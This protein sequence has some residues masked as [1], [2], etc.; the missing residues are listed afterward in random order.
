MSLLQLLA[1]DNYIPVNK[2]FIKSFGLAEAVL[3][4]E[5]C[6]EYTY[7]ENEDKLVDDMFYCS[8]AKLEDRTGLS[9]YQQR[10]A[11]QSLKNAGILETSL[12]GCPATKY[13]KINSDKL[14]NFL[15]TSSKKT[16]QLDVKKLQPSNN[17]NIK[18]ENKKDIISKDIISVQKPEFEFGKPKEKKLS[19]YHKCVAHVN[20]FT[21][22]DPD[23]RVR[24]LLLDFLN[25]LVDMGK[26]R[27][28]KQFVGILNKLKE[29]GDTEDKKILIIKTSIEHGWASFYEYKEAPKGYNKPKAASDIGKHAKRL[30]DEQKR[31]SQEDIKNGRA[32]K[33]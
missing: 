27:G 24:N 4:G 25:S 31:Q 15:T 2:T 11:I 10:S 29:Y 8:A 13:F 28:E 18:K 6:S 26:L 5:L 7:W 30:T 14:F 19:L 33:F 23:S 21:R 3:L 32:E 9:Q 17:I 1:S 12:K 20:D 22:E 16:A